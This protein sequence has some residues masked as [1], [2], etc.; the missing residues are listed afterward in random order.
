LLSSDEERPLLL[1]DD[2]ESNRR[3]TLMMSYSSDGDGDTSRGGTS[4]TQTIQS[5]FSSSDAWLSS[6]PVKKSRKKQSLSPSK[7]NHKSY[8]ENI[9]EVSKRSYYEYD[10]EESAS[11]RERAQEM[12]M[13]LRKEI[14]KKKVRAD[15]KRLDL[16]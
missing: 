11:Q 2:A 3:L 1:Q 7:R 16:L 8:Y 12:S 5:D 14:R 13:I 10:D 6:S 4:T 15:M 9:D